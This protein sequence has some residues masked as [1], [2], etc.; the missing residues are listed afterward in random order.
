MADTTLPGDE[1]TLARLYNETIDSHRVYLKKLHE[2]FNAHCEEIGAS[3][4]TNLAK[5]DE[6]DAGKR[7]EILMKEQGELDKTLAELKY[8]INRSSA[9]ARKK[10]EEIQNKLDSGSIDLEAELAKI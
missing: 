6:S 9:D 4:K 5:I 2:A 1:Q 8:A 7:K 3:A 10:L